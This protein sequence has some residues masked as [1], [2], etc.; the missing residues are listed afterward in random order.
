MD[1]DGAKSMA[2]LNG[3]FEGINWWKLLPDAQ[4]KLVTAGRG[5]LGTTGYV[6]AAAA[7]DGTLAVAYVPDGREITVDLGQLKG[8]V[9][10][11]IFD[12]AAGTFSDVA[13][14]PF[15]NGGSQ[16][17]DPPGSNDAVLLLQAK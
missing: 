6:T 4:S 7:A 13:G 17:I 8:S 9:G 15:A 5:T 2:N 16:K 3:F 11:R 1:A 14:S 10:A 12:P